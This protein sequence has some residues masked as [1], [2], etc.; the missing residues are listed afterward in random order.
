MNYSKSIHKMT[1][2]VLNTPRGEECDHGWG[3]PDRS[4]RATRIFKKMRELLIERYRE[5]ERV[6][7]K[8]GKLE[9]W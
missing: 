4:G 7:Q 6:E 2:P 1:P 5:K 3:W 8:G 9:M